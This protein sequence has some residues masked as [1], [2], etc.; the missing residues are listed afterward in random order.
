MMWGAF[1]FK[2]DTHNAVEKLFPGLFLRNQDWAYLWISSR[3][4]NFILCQ[5]EVYQIILKLSCRPHV[6]TSYKAFLENRKRSRTSF[7]ASFSAWFLKMF[8][9]CSINWP[10]FIFWLPVL[11]EILGNMEVWNSWVTKSA[12]TQNDVTL[13]VTNSKTFTE[14]L[15]SSY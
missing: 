4:F 12:L 2:N 11:H 8:V 5:V 10:N 6:F 9:L 15:L 1:F 13:R 7:H 3:K 14:I